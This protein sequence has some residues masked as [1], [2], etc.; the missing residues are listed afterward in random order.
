MKYDNRF[1]A[2]DTETG[3]L[4]TQLKKVAT[5]EVALTEIAAVVVDN[6]KLEI[7]SKDSWLIKPYDS[8]LIYDKFAEQ[9]S[10][11]SKAMCEKEGME[12]ETVYN[13]FKTI[14]QKNKKG[15]CLPIIIF[16]NKPFDT[17]FIVNLFKLFDD[18]FYKYIDRIEDT[19][20]WARLKYVEKPNFKLA[21]VSQYCGLDH[22]Q[23]HR[24]LPD[25]IITAECWIHFMKCLRGDVGE[26]KKENK[27]RYTFKF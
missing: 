3:G 26:A 24:A 7:L 19:M 25:T 16:H 17:E 15:K 13:N 10:G 23:A 6:E 20:E 18:D 14:L 4:P 1:I 2:V 12:I 27:F 22:V 5:I 8:S 11:I 21:S 9:A